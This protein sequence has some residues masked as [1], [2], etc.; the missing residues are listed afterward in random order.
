[1]RFRRLSA[2]VTALAVA[3]AWTGVLSPGTANAQTSDV[4]VRPGA[5]HGWSVKFTTNAVR[6]G[7]VTGPAGGLGEGAF[8]FDT[9]A[10]GAARAGA[11]VELSN[12]GL[13]DQPLADLTA[14]H[15]DVYLE[16]NDPGRSSRT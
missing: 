15:F 9:G 14:L 6:P 3:T 11:K 7:F 1:M 8:R 4:V 13:N 10:P 2:F 5:L 16:E 12:G